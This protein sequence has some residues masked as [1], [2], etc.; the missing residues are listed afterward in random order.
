MF[1][2]PHRPAKSRTEPR[3]PGAVRIRVVRD[4]AHM[5]PLVDALAIYIGA[6]TGDLASMVANFTSEFQEIND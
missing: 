6:T 1:E 5:Q 3:Q 4:R 2:R